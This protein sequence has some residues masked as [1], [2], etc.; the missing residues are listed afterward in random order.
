[1][2]NPAHENASI[3]RPSGPRQTTLA[4]P[5]P[6]PTTSDTSVAPTTSETVTPSR[7]LTSLLTD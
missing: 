4:T 6:T 7:W 3:A 1:M 2:A 5:R